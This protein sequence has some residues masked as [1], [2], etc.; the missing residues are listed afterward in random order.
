MSD[1]PEWILEWSQKA[2]R[3]LRKLEKSVVERLPRKLA[4]LRQNPDPKD[5]LKALRENRSGQHRLR[6]QEYRAILE[7]Y[8]VQRILL[9]VEVGHRKDIYED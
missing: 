8:E 3:Q 1:S 7:I 2:D 9:V 5:H 4:W 6:V